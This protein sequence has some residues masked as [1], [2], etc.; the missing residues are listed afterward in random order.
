MSK[1]LNCNYL[2]TG[3]SLITESVNSIFSWCSDLLQDLYIVSGQPVHNLSDYTCKI[4]EG[5][6]T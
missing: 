4:P 5:Q 2:N 6:I 3:T 1:S